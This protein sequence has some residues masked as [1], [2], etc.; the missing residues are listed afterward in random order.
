[1]INFSTLQGLTI[2]EGVVTQIA[3]VSGR[4][5]WAIQEESGEP[6]VLQVAKQTITTYAGETSY[7]GESFVLLD[8]YPKKSNS[9]VN[10]TYGGLTK[11]LTFSGTNAQQVYF[12]TFNGVSDATETP[13]SGTLTI[14]GG[15]SSFGC[16]V[17][18]KSSKSTDYG[19]CPCIA[20]VA[21]W[22]SVTSIPSH[23]F[24]GCTSLVLTK[25]PDG[26]TS[27]PSYAFRNCASLVLTELPSGITSIADFAFTMSGVNLSDV[28]MKNATL[29]FPDSLES[30]GQQAFI[31]GV[32][33]ESGYVTYLGKVVMRAKPPPAVASD[34]FGSCNP[35]LC[36]E[37]GANMNMKL[38][39]VVPK[40][41]GEL[42]K[43]AENWSN[44]ADWITEES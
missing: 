21:E 38:P 25:L 5:L 28:A 36:K 30:I 40:G 33:V 4:V 26:I 7:A 37:P 3:D 24:D 6:I 22:G 29:V 32:Y 15:C 13:A 16:G 41:C 18:Q 19:Y 44:S 12:G 14:E 42:Y 23:A 9:I 11:T 27:I 10:V 34:T 20:T 35:W 2:P 17:Y 1:M 31:S 43:A 39:I 8:I